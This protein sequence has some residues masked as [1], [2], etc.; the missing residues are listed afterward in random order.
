MI[1][2][3]V[4]ILLYVDNLWNQLKLDNI[5]E[6]LLLLAS[7]MNCRQHLWKNSQIKCDL[8]L[9]S[10]ISF[11]LKTKLKKLWPSLSEAQPKNSNAPC[12]QNNVKSISRV[13][14]KHYESVT[15]CDLGG[16]PIW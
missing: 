13:P 9:F 14:T 7:Q 16:N 11:I 5:S 1:V 15:H 8:R 6:S 4:S 2:V 12:L 3:A 10:G